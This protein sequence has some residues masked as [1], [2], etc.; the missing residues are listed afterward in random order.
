M[1]NLDEKIQLSVDRLAHEMLGSDDVTATGDYG[2]INKDGVMVV[3]RRYISGEG[4]H[5]VFVAGRKFLF[6]FRK[7]FINGVVVQTDGT[8]RLMTSDE[9]GDYD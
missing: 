3:W 9:V 8:R 1:D 5:F 7:K 6:V 2:T 4:I